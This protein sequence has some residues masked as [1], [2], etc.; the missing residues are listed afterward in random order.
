MIQLI[1]DLPDPLLI[2]EVTMKIYLHYPEAL[3]PPFEST[4]FLNHDPIIDFVY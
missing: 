4:V 2:G 3:L 1:E